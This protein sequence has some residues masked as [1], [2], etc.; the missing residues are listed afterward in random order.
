[1]AKFTYRTWAARDMEVE[2]DEVSFEGDYVVFANVT[3]GYR[4]KFI[5]LAERSSNVNGLRQVAT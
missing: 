4:D 1:M 3:P 5:V 2:A